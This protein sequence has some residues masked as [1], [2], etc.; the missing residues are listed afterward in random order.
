MLLRKLKQI[1]HVVRYRSYSESKHTIILG[2]SCRSIGHEE[3]GLDPYVDCL[4]GELPE[5]DA[6]MAHV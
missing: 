1:L 2:Y 5:P 3:A 6:I 4:P